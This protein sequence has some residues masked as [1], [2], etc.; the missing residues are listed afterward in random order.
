MCEGSM[1]VTAIS[2]VVGQQATGEWRA[3]LCRDMGRGEGGC[4]GKSSRGAAYVRD[5]RWLPLA[6]RPA[7][8]EDLLGVIVL[9]TCLCL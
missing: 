4:R 3:L 2:C 5:W 7:S 1:H 6:S 9:G 8:R